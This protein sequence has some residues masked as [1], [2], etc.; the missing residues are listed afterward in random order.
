MRG[1]KSYHP[2]SSSFLAIL[3]CH[4]SS[5]SSFWKNRLRS[6]FFEALPVSNSIDWWCSKWDVQC[7]T[8]SCWYWESCLMRLQVVNTE[9]LE[10]PWLFHR[11]ALNSTQGKRAIFW[12][13]KNKAIAN[14]VRL[15]PVAPAASKWSLHFL[16]ALLVACGFGTTG[17]NLEEQVYAEYCHCLEGLPGISKLI[18]VTIPGG[19][20]WVS[21]K[22]RCHHCGVCFI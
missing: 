16:R 15:E 11:K 17:L 7:K 8:F 6:G 18:W 19:A 10:S 12:P 21:A 20:E 14:G 2:S 5:P 9:T 1:E 22:A 13:Q 4:P 3:P